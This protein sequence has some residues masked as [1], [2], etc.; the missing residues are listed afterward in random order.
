[1][2]RVSLGSERDILVQA[3]AIN[4]C[5][6]HTFHWFVRCV[7]ELNHDCQVGLLERGVRKVRDDLAE[8]ER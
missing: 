4:H 2:L 5:F 6:N 8:I 1:M 7:L 3:D